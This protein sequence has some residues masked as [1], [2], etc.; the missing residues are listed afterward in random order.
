MTVFGGGLNDRPGMRLK[1]MLKEKEQTKMSELKTKL[2]ELAMEILQKDVRH[3]S[4]A[5]L[6][7]EFGRIQKEHQ[8]LWNKQHDYKAII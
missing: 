5:L 6:R 1:N 7:R 4:S 3:E 8:K 2:K